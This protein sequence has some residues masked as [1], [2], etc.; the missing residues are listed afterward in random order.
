MKCPHC[1][2]G[3]KLEIEQY[4]TYELK[5]ASSDKKTGISLS[6]GFCPQC[7]ELI[8][9]IERGEY[10]F[11]DGEGELINSEEKSFL[12][13][14]FSKRIV[15][16]LVPDYY[17]NSLN[18]ANDV[19]GISPKSSAALSRR[20]LQSILRDEYQLKPDNLAKQIDQFIV[21]PNI[22]S[23]VSKAVDAIR[24]IGNFS[25]HP[26][27]F[28]HTGEIVDVEVGEAEW[29]LDVL[30]EIFDITFIQPQQTQARK[31]KLNQ[32]LADLGDKPMKE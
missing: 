30:E 3:I 25:A 16:S 13:P 6:H 32:K 4:H 29:L 18:E 2:I 31:D 7:N 5:E 19:L 20:L 22:P 24:N 21:L 17:R 9:I 11:I 8:V 27:K 1:N 12:Y 23:Y 15:D 14:K 28:T 10:K 26:N